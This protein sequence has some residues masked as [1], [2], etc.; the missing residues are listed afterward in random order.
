MKRV[1][2][3][4]VTQSGNDTFTAE[5]IPMPALDGKSGYSIEALLIKSTGLIAGAAAD[6]FLEGVVQTVDTATTLDQDEHIISA[7]WGQAY[8]GAAGSGS[9]F[10]PYIE[11]VLYDP[12]IT[13][14]PELF[15]AVNSSATGLSNEIEYV[16]YFD[17]VKLSEIEY[18]RLLSGGS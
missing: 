14:Q 7:T 16:L 10:L 18:L 2:R 3:G 8:Q 5:E 9:I 15:F 12:R 17:I 1:I 6:W 13:V 11:H 4:S